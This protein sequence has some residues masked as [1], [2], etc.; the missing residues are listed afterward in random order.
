M[1]VGFKKIISKIK[2]QNIGPNIRSSYH[3]ERLFAINCTQDVLTW[4]IEPKPNPS[5][6]RSKKS[7]KVQKGYH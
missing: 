6:R 4:K 2:N 3:K 1:D 5:I 7:T